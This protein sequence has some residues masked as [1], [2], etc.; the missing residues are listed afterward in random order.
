MSLTQYTYSISVDFPNSIVN[1]TRL[2][3]EIGLSNITRALNHID[4]IGDNCDIWFKDA[5]VSG[6]PGVLSGVVAAHTGAANDPEYN[7]P[8][9]GDSVSISVV[10]NKTK[11]SSSMMVSHNYADP[12]TWYTEAGQQISGTLSWNGSYYTSAHQNWI[13]LYHRRLTD[14]QKI[15]SNYKVSVW[16]DDVLKTEDIDYTINYNSGIVIPSTW[17]D[18]GQNVKAT[19]HYAS[20]TSFY[21]QPVEGKKLVLSDTEIQRS[22]DINLSAQDFGWFEIQYNHP[23]Y[24]WIV[25]DSRRYGSYKDFINTS[26]RSYPLFPADMEIP[27]D[28]QIMR[29]DYLSL[30]TLPSSDYRICVRIENDT[31]YD[32][33]LFV[34]TLYALFENEDS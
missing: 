2:S 5:L 4:T 21:W 26:N 12:C 6:E 22:M 9:D 11:Q 28:V 15:Q 10:T 8:L 32:G 18:S 7:Y 34:V 14:E 29:W 20:G 13:D 17:S 1:T 31:V 19:Y 30:V 25:A 23:T 3:D 33:T 27:V 24:G 16:V